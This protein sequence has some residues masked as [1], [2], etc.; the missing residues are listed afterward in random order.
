MRGGDVRERYALGSGPLLTYVGRLD[1]DK[2]P[3][4]LVGCLAL[5]H[6]RYPD[7]TLACAANFFSISSRA[8]RSAVPD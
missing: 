4:D 2:F 8:S 5:V 6:E 1:A 3:L 7:A